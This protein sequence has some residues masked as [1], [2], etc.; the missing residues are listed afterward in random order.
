[1]QMFQLKTRSH[2][3]RWAAAAAVAV[4][5]SPGAAA[6]SLATIQG[7]VRSGKGKVVEG[8]E[9]VVVGVH[10]PEKRTARTDAGGAFVVP[11]LPPDEY[12][13]DTSCPT[14]ADSSTTVDLGAGQQRR[15]DL[16]VETDSA[17]TTI[18]LDT[19]ATTIDASSARIGGNVTA[20]EMAGLPVN[21]GTYAPL[22][23]GT[24]GAVNAGPASFNDIRFSGQSAEQNR[25]TVD[26]VDSSAVVSASPGFTA[27]PGFQF[28][29]RTSIDTIQE[30]RVE[31]AATP[32]A[33][34]GVLGGYVQL[35]S[36]SGQESWHGSAFEYFRNSALNARNYFDEARSPLH[37]NQF[38]GMAGGRLVPNRLFVLASV[39]GLRQKAGVNTIETTPAGGALAD[40]EPAIAAIAAA[41]PAGSSIGDGLAVAQRNQ[42]AIQNEQSYALRLDYLP[43]PGSRL[44]LRAQHSSGNLNSPDQT[45]SSR[46]IL[47]NLQSNHVV[48]SLH[49]TAGSVVN[50]LL[51]GWNSSPTG[52]SV[53]GGTPLLT[54]AR[55][56]AGEITGGIVSPGGLSTLPDGDLGRGAQYHGRSYQ[57][58][59]QLTWLYGKHAFQFGAESL[60]LRAPVR[61]EGGMTYHYQ[62]VSEVFL[63]D[64][65]DVTLIGDL[66]A[67]VAAREEYGF[68]AQDDWRISPSLTLNLGIRYEYFG[69]TRETGDRGRLLDLT[70]F[71]DRSVQGGFYS[72]S[73]L[74]FAPR[75]GLAWAPQRLKG[76]TVVR[77]GGGIFQG[78]Y[79][80]LDT[81][82]PIVNDTDR[83]VVIGGAYPMTAAEVKSNPSVRRI[84]L[85]L[86]ASSFGAMMRN[87]QAALSIQQMLPGK[88]M[89]QAAAIGSVSRHLT[90][91]GALNPA[92]GIND[93]GHPYR[94]NPGFDGVPVTTNGGRSS[95]QALQ[96]G[97]SRRFVDDLTVNLAYAHSHSIGD[98]AG[99]GEALPVQNPACLA[100]ERGDNNFDVRHTLSASVLY[101]LPFGTG[102]RHLQHG[103][104][105]RLAGGWSLGGIWNV[106]S[107]LPLN[108]TINRPDEVWRDTVTGAYEEGPNS[109]PVMNVP[110]GG[111]GRPAL[112]PNLV[113]GVDPYLSGGSTLWLNP[114]AFTAPMLGTF[115]NLGRNALRGPGFQQ[116]DVQISR[117]FQ[118]SEGHAITLRFDVFNAFN[119]ENFANPTV[120]LSDQIGTLAPGQ[121][122]STETAAGFAA[123][124]ST[125]GRTV[126]LGTSRQ[127]QVSLR[128]RF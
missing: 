126:G 114:A 68:Y 83:Y 52:M 95:Y 14:C 72:T 111:E 82:Q 87:Y 128:Y 93:E 60:I 45:A 105:S 30:F 58:G 39:E 46:S 32:A 76:K 57:L 125:V 112:R 74:G 20:A 7:T 49:L 25:F 70:T 38:G 123:L 19:T 33:Q 15:L 106:R 2:M 18:S 94:Q 92:V 6:Q 109:V 79:A 103:L 124:S 44:F 73:R 54:G 4:A 121:P 11:Q 37:L 88:F 120:V 119:H 40:A 1:M 43:I 71:A 113:P 53:D 62:D 101:A 8:V 9:I 29:L 75:F 117:N 97:V 64:D 23:L 108:V 104:A 85:A 17:S 90:Q 51:A 86:D 42:T 91:L 27:A 102:R 110:G 115:G 100:C 61:I 10:T 13:L 21:G 80:F 35:V 36:K 69:P 47:A 127:V 31:S 77:F 81:L 99:S 41:Y 107:G 12:R 26:G 56:L 118:V 55:I 89:A 3:C 22:E 78:S 66:S 16:V 63:N 50:E 67:H 28:R 116:F 65:A 34:G 98:T 96:F 59:D 122:Y 5:L 84:P 24:P 48:S